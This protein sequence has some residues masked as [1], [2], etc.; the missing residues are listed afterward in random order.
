MTEMP[1]LARLAS[2]LTSTK[3]DAPVMAA[4]RRGTRGMRGGQ[5][6]G[7]GPAAPLAAAG[8]V[9]DT[10]RRPSPRPTCVRWGETLVLLALLALGTAAVLTLA[11]DMHIYCGACKGLFDEI[12][13]RISQGERREGAFDG[14]RSGGLGLREGRGRMW[15]WRRLA[16]RER[17]RLRSGAAQDS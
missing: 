16:G 9:A 15:S 13:Y 5:R 3:V 10:G 12:D 7:Y 2:H 14:L 4:G 17:S 6:R 11:K 1:K 8:L